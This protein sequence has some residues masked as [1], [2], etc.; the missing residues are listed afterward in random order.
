MTEIVVQQAN[1]TVQIASPGPV[2]PSPAKVTYQPGGGTV[3]GTQPT[4]N[5]APLITGYYSRVGEVVLFQIDVDFDN[6][7]S[8]GTGQYFLTL[9]FKAQY[10][11][12]VR[13]GCLHNPMND[14][15]YQIAGHLA[16]GSNVLT[17]WTTGT[18]GQ[19]DGFD[20]NNPIQLHPDDYFHVAGF[21]FA[22]TT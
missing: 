19:D 5:G 4:F 1:N 13:G 11:T 12:M 22:Q 17:L 3:D 7:I 16:A 8:F 18:Q 15:Q 14:R 9:P 20:N 6:I 2:G 21:Y 10:D